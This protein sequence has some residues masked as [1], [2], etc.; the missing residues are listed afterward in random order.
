LG[1]AIMS[2]RE[3]F[4]SGKLKDGVAISS[5]ERNGNN[6]FRPYLKPTCK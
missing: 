5:A 1:G 2:C 3:S 6:Y 4:G